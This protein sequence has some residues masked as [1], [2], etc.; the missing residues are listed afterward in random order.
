MAFSVVNVFANESL[1]VDEMV[2]NGYVVCMM[3]CLVD[4]KR[5]IS[6]YSMY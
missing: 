1:L 2:K 4:C 3:C 6:R 5:I